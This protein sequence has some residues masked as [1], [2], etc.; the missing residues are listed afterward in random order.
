[1]I[2]KENNLTELVMGVASSDVNQVAQ[3][4]TARA[5]LRNHMIT[6][7]RTLLSQL[8]VEIGLIQ[9]FID[10]PVDDAF[11]EMPDII[12]KQL[13]P[14]DVKQIKAFFEENK[15]LDSFKQAVVWGRLF[16]GAGL[17][18]NM[19]QNPESELRLDRLSKNSKIALYPLDRW[20][21]NFQVSGDT[22]IEGIS[23]GIAASD[24]PYNIYGQQVHKSRVLRI[25]GKQCPSILRLQ[26]GGWGMS[27]V[28]RVLRSINSFLKD[29]DVIF[30]LLDEAKVD[31]YKVNGYNSALL[32]QGGTTNINKQLTLSNKL[33][34]FLNALVMDK[35][36]EYEQKNMNF[37][38][39]SEMLTQIRQSIAADLR[40][41]MTKL[42]G[43]SAS[44]FNS[45]EDDLENYNSMVESE[46]RAKNKSSFITLVQAACQ[47]LFGFI[48]DDIDIEWTSLRVLSAEQEESV[49]DKRY[50][51]LM[52]AYQQQLITD[53]QFADACTKEGLLSGISFDNVHGEYKQDEDQPSTDTEEKKNSKWWKW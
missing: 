42:F 1:M 30:E 43:L 48:P 26:L 35:E 18:I 19:P 22:S 5:N 32:T 39:L 13:D 20:E 33:K 4:D 15:W 53:E 46:V 24:K 41:P 6:N 47:I 51:R 2:E 10:Q 11:R 17:F 12:S 14:D 29:H 25:S 16:G 34:S 37:A 52:Q 3:A 9:A 7:D 28:E 8:Y 21:L 40:M 44:G 49:K 36:D 27:E 45:G 38:G 50:N 23:N 31:V